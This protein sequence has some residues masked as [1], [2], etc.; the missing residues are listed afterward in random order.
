MRE[1]G[2]VCARG[3]AKRRE[4]VADGRGGGGEEGAGCLA[5]QLLVLPVGE[6]KF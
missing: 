1:S 3:G 2:C 6:L 5:E 4:R